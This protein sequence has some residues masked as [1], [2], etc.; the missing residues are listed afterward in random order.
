VLRR[1]D[2]RRAPLRERALDQT[3]FPRMIGDDHHGAVR[4]EAIAQ[5]R[6]GALQNAQLVVHGDAQCLEEGCELRWPAPRSQHGTDGTHEVVTD[7]ERTGSPSPN[8]FARNAARPR[9]V[10]VFAKDTDQLTLIA[11]I[12]DARRVRVRVGTHAHVEWCALPESESAIAFIE[13]VGGH[14]EIEQD[15]VPRCSVELRSCADLG[16]IRANDP[17]RS[18]AQMRL[19]SARGRVDSRRILIDSGDVSAALEEGE[20]VSAS[21]ERT[22][23]DVPSVAEQLGDLVGENWRVKGWKSGWL[24]HR[25]AVILVSS[26]PARQV[27]GKL[28]V[29]QSA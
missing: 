21:S 10:G 23:Q 28:R 6:E 19:Q 17:E 12:E 29:V 11:V 15:A 5:H 2:A 8:D 24:G 9:F 25:N 27:F 20:G 18:A 3:V 16:E 4:Q 22:V 26:R 1:A 13:L 14:T 7:K